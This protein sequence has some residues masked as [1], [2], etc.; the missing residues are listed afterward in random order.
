MVKKKFFFFFTVFKINFLARSCLCISFDNRKLHLPETVPVNRPQPRRPDFLA[1]S[2]HLG[3]G[4]ALPR[5]IPPPAPQRHME[6][7]ETQ[8]N[9]EKG[10]ES[11]DVSAET[12]QVDH[13]KPST[14]FISTAAHYIPSQLLQSRGRG[15]QGAP[16][17]LPSS[18]SSPLRGRGI[19]GAPS[20][21]PPSQSFPLGFRG[22]GVQGPLPESHPLRNKGI[23]D[24]IISMRQE[25]KQFLELKLQK[26]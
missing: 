13:T 25:M 21:L 8:T 4:E 7:V 2:H 24:E 14:S 16:S 17:Q 19:Q 10:R 5:L 18:Q 6:L 3:L 26:R 22:R 15:V 9:N 23:H 20:Q 11:L 12:V 1:S